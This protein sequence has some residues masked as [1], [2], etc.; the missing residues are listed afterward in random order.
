MDDMISN[1]PLSLALL[2][3]LAVFYGID[4]GFMSRYD[5]DRQQGKGW[6]W[7]YTLSTLGA[8][9]VI[10]LQPR[11]WPRLG[12]WTASPFGLAVQIL[13]IAGA[14]ASFIVHA[15]SRLHLQ[16]FYAERV[17]VQSDH[18]VIQSGPYALVRHPV[19]A[20][21]FLFSIGLFLL[22]PALP[23]ALALLYTAWDFTRAA[24]QE[25]AL[26]S[27][28]LPEYAAYMRRVPRF[29]PSLRRGKR[30]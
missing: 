17:E 1:L 11:L 18:E 16:K 13:G 8:A 20:S 19:F 25:E 21:F 5:R 24:R 12:W 10:V 9:L 23:T 7:D 27:K 26:L 30:D 14:L 22:N 2:I 3:L 29:I 15:W 6:S 4:F 28:K